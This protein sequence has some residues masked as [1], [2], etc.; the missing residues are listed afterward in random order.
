MFVAW[1]HLA[2]LVGELHR[3]DFPDDL[4]A[5]RRRALTPGAY[6][7]RGCEETFTEQDLDEEGNA[8]TAAYYA[9]DESVYMADYT[10]TV[11]KG[12]PSRYHVPDTWETFERL[13]PILDARLRQW[14]SARPFTELTTDAL[15]PRKPWWRFW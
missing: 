2:G 9:G 6:F 10:S 3:Y 8:F 1:A 15:Q 4:A 5:L 11:A 13:R 7:I 14:R 12:L